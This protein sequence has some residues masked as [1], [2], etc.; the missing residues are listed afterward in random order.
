MGT[1]PILTKGSVEK[2][3]RLFAV[4]I[5]LTTSSASAQ[6]LY[7]YTDHL[8]ST[9]LQTESS[10]N[11][12]GL[13]QYTP[14][15]EILPPH[16]NPL[17]KGERAKSEG[18][19]YLF[20]GQELDR[21]SDLQNYGARHYDPV[22]SRFV[23]VDP[24]LDGLN[25]YAYVQNNPLILTDPTGKQAQT[26]EIEGFRL[27]VATELGRNG[28][29]YV[30]MSHTFEGPRGLK[31]GVMY[32]FYTRGEMQ[33]SP[34]L[35]ENPGGL[36]AWRLNRIVHYA[37]GYA[38]SNVPGDVTHISLQIS[39][40]TI[41]K[42]RME[43]A[44]SNTKE[45]LRKAILATKGRSAS[46]EETNSQLIQFQRSGNRLFLQARVTR[47]ASQVPLILL[48][49]QILTSDNPA[50][51]AMETVEEA[52]TP[53]VLSTFQDMGEVTGGL[54]DGTI[55]PPEDA[56]SN[57]SEGQRPWL[58]RLLDRSPLGALGGNPPSE[59]SME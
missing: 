33:I 32:N 2:I 3:M 15:G 54:L 35:V 49:Y 37:L 45:T 59:E 56:G 30:R 25:S 1:I 6:T 39:P 23:S 10:G 26:I 29:N 12:R 51:A 9:V 43:R 19:P 16:P 13:F 47:I 46:F 18:V 52:V 38:I 4:L 55:P 24:I 8:G 11:V 27:K 34:L 53:P 17:P 44:T 50:E 21:E 7:G 57:L 36:V 42:L 58:T 22:L 48:F 28:D 20:T 14:F 41:A 5:I 31:I 40:R